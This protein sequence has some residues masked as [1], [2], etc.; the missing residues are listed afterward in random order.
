MQLCRPYLQA[1]AEAVHSYSRPFHA[2]FV[3]IAPIFTDSPR[4]DLA[5]FFAAASAMNEAKPCR[6]P[7]PHPT[8]L[9]HLAC[10]GATIAEAASTAAAPI[11]A[12]LH[13]DLE[14]TVMEIMFPSV[15]SAR[16][17]HS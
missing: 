7:V 13:A 6:A 4:F 14:V 12:N 10:A 15:A 11:N 16:F 17:G 1:L 3:D 9:M 8:V 2:H 5:E